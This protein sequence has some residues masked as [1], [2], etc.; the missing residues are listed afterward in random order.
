MNWKIIFNPFIKFSEKQLLIFGIVTTIAGSLI[1]SLV[2]VTFDGL[3]D[4]H[5]NPEMTFLKSLKENGILILLITILL[6]AFGKIINPKTRFIDILNSAFLFRIPFYVSA[7]LTSLP[8]MKRV[9]EEVMK[10][11]NSIEN[12]NLQTSDIIIM[13]LISVVTIGLIAYAITLL[14]QGF[15]TATNAKKAVH[16]VVFGILIFVGEIISSY[17]FSIL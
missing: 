17:I 14:F 6:F 1:A 4:I 8:V 16:Y 9:S 12:L 11:V 2:G 13:L 10:N 5:I 7:L 15:K 3:I